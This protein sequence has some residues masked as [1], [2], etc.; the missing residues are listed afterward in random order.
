VV[1]NTASNAVTLLGV[2]TG[3]STASVPVDT[4]PN[5]VAIDPVLNYAAVTAATENT[6]DL[7]NL[8]DSTIVGRISAQE[9]P[10]G[11]VF[12]PVGNMFVVADSVENNVTLID[13]QT[14]QTTSVRTGIN[15]VSLDYNFQT[16][17]LV[18]ANDVSNTIS[19][20]DYLSQTVQA[21]LPIANSAMFSVAIDPLSNMAVVAD[22]AN[23]RVL[24]VPLP[25]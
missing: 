16:S 25:H 19:V 17:T 13:P 10:T 3:V 22:Q 12:D 5:A 2:D 9:L 15:P 7:V 4:Y 21:V 14:L 24:I 1:A 6:V 20:I 23:N 18:T 8:A 11:V